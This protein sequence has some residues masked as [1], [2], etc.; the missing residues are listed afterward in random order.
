MNVFGFF[1][2]VFA[3]VFAGV[4][5]VVLLKPSRITSD[6]ARAKV[7]GRARGKDYSAL[8]CVRVRVSTCVYVCVCVR[9]CACV[10][11]RVC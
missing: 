1:V 5:S 10:C 6:N 3:S 2:C 8:L 4:C 9:V 11:V 7:S